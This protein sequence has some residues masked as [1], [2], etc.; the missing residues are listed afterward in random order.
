MQRNTKQHT[1]PQPPTT[2]VAAKLSAAR[3]ALSSGAS[4][5]VDAMRYGMSLLDKSQRCAARVRG[6]C[7]CVCICGTAVA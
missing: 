5:Q 4:A 2:Q 7:V 1:T 6:M 3:A